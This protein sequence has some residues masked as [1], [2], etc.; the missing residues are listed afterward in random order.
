M[1]FKGVK[2]RV[3]TLFCNIENK[4]YSMQSFFLFVILDSYP[5]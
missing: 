2:E 1:F 3:A 4:T 5:E